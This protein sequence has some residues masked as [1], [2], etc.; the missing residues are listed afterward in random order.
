MPDMYPGKAIKMGD[1]RPDVVKIVQSRLNEAGCGLL[2]IDGQFG[3]KTFASVMMYQ[4]RRGLEADGIVGPITWGSLFGLRPMSIDYPESPLAKA[5]LD[6]ARS[7]V[8]VREQGG[9]N[10]GP[11]VEKYLAA[12]G[13]PPGHAWCV[14]FLIWC[15]KEACQRL[16]A[17]CPLPPVASVHVLWNRTPETM[18]IPPSAPQEED[19]RLVKPG[20][21]YLIDHGQDMGH[22]G[23]VLSATSN[24]LLGIEGNTNIAG[25]REGDG[26]YEKSRRFAAINLGY[27]DFASA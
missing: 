7:Q 16:G 6:V 25:S 12:V 3:P 15:A 22:A 21:L 14:A 11:P 9:A 5:M 13:L 10:R 18:R 8:G 26:V 20:A 17:V 27:I 1:R 24:G 4:T 19:L 2:R 23:L